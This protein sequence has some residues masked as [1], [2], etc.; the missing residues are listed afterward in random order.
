MSAVFFQHKR[1]RKIPTAVF[2]LKN[3]DTLVIKIKRS[4]VELKRL[5]TDRNTYEISMDDVNSAV[6]ECMEK[7][8][9]I[10]C[11]PET[12]EK[13]LSLKTNHA[14]DESFKKTELYQKM[15]QYQRDGI[16]HVVRKF[17]GRALIAD[18]MGLGKTLQ[19]IALTHYYKTTKVLVICPAYLRFNWKCEF[20]KWLGIKEVCLLTKG[21]D[22]LEGYPVITS[23]ELAVKKRDELLKYGFDFII[24]DE[25]HYLKNTKTKRTRGL[26]PLVQ[27]IKY[28]TLLTGTPAL[29]RPCELYSQVNMINKEF[30]PKYKHFAERYCDRKMSHLGFW[31]DTGSSNPHEVHWLAKKT[32]MIRRLKRDVLKDLPKKHRSQLHINL[33]R[34]DVYEMEP[35]FEEWATLNREI[36]KMAPCSEEVKRADF[37]RK[38]VINELYSL[39][40]ECKARAIELLIKDTMLNGK[41]FLVFCYHKGLMDAIEE[42]CEGKSMRIDGDTPTEKRHEYVKGFQAGEYQVAVLSMLAAG[43]GITLTAASHVI[44]AELYWTPGVL[45]QSEDRVHRIGQRNPCHIQYVIAK[46]TLDPYLYKSIQWKLDTIDDCLDQRDDRNF[47]GKDSIYNMM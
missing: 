35:L 39:T 19:A 40:A 36:P 27:K 11:V 44:F 22:E 28:A 24:C 6:D 1:R 26:R 9:F 38:V 7:G 16:E 42:A 31:D 47:K 14:F 30:F 46:D 20:E 4:N 32:C 37:R 41:Q 3:E 23:Y 45:L 5:V 18:D 2:S 21:T 29:N 8:F 15:F 25:S 17:M 13:A 34:S 43:T 33:E 10:E 12:V